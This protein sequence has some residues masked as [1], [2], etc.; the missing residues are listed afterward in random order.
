MR[1]LEPNT[2]SARQQ[3]L[4]QSGNRQEQDDEAEQAKDG[5]AAYHSAAVRPAAVT[6]HAEHHD[7]GPGA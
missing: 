1:V 3:V 5:H 7:R 4:K 6:H 2:F